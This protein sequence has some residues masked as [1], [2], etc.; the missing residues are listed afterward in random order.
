MDRN[1]YTVNYIFIFSN[2]CGGLLIALLREYALQLVARVALQT[3]QH[4]RQARGRDAPWQDPP[5][6]HL[7]K[8]AFWQPS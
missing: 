3:A 1:A 5:S 7:R 8:P 6:A 4:F 2:M